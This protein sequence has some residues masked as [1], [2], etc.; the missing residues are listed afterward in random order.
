MK[1][2][3][4]TAAL[5]LWLFGFAIYS[6]LLPTRNSALLHSLDQFGGLLILVT[7]AAIFFPSK[8]KKRRYDVR[9]E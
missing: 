3:L 6:M 4:L 7:L 2:V 9:E 1:I 5:L 8:T